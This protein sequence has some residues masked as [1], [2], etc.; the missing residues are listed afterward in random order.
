MNI[1]VQNLTKLHEPIKSSLL[2]SFS[3]CIE[4][5]SFIGGAAVSDFEESCKESFGLYNA[6]SCANG[7]DALE[8][9]MRACNIKAGDRVVVTSL[10]WVSSA[11]TIALVGAIPVF[12]DIDPETGL[13]DLDQLS[14]LVEK[15][16]INGV[17]IVHMYA[18]VVDV[19]QIHDIV[20]S[21]GCWIIEDCAQA[22]LAKYQD[23]SVGT[24]ADFSTFSFYPGKNLGA[25]GDAGM[26]CTNNSDLAQ[27]AR[28]ISLHGGLVKHQH[29]VI[30]RN[31]R[32]D[33]IQA[34][35]LSLKLPYLEEWTIKRERVAEFYNNN[36]DKKVKRVKQ[37]KNTRNVWHMYPIICKN[38]DNLKE[39][40]Q[41]DFNIETLINYPRPLHHLKCFKGVG[42]TP[43]ALD[44]VEKWCNSVLCIP[45][46]P[47]LEKTEL[48]YIVNAVNELS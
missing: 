43:L 34:S 44:N 41:S 37:P 5:S 42:K 48:T 4:S 12:C 2:R 11:S 47:T 9:S 8:I 35:F 14:Y 39:K 19:T 32:L 40:L 31:S 17:V 26:I 36:L 7:T 33:T 3:D 30:G 25:L 6:I 1:K 23:M 21:H 18:L 13:L 27:K 24:L 38:R 29:D 20:R 45:M 10:T 28:K 16:E 46:C 15:G 22:H